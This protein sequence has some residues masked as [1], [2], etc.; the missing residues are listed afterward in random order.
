MWTKM[1]NG[2]D[3]NWNQAHAYCFKLQL[4]GYSDWRLPAIEELDGIYDDSVG[5][6]TVFDF[7]DAVVRVKGNLKL[8]GWDWSSSEG[9]TPRQVQTYT[10]AANPSAQRARPIFRSFSYSMRALCVRGSGVVPE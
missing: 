5:I 10:F 1:D 6:R 3:L 2:S 8:T 9:E 7:G 4:G